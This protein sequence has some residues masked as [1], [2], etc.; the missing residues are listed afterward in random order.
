MPP[1]AGARPA[2]GGRGGRRRPAV[3]AGP[4]PRSRR[5]RARRPAPRPGRSAPRSVPPGSWRSSRREPVSPPASG[6]RGW[7]S[8]TLR[9]GSRSAGGAAT[10]R[11]GD[12]AGVGAG[13]ADAGAGARTGVSGTS[14]KRGAS[15]GTRGDTWPASRA[16]AASSAPMMRTPSAGLRG[17]RDAPRPAHAG[18]GSVP[19]SS[20]S[21]AAP[22]GSPG[23]ALR[24]SPWSS[25]CAL[26][27]GART[28]AGPAP[29]RARGGGS[30]PPVRP[31]SLLDLEQLL[32]LARQHARRSRPRTRG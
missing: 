28:P 12:G 22:N 32:L 24:S 19:S 10:G 11:L 17:P 23:L 7:V 6:G 30:V 15:S 14:P 31:E 3:A 29:P 1:P 9:R 18:P 2:V 20:S 5:C 21:G 13:E 25:T 27:L 8:Q 4:A 26:L 16:A